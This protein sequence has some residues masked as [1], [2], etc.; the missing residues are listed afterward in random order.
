MATSRS[1]MGRMPGA[2]FRA[3]RAWIAGEEKDA[4]FY[5][6]L[7][8]IRV[9]KVLGIDILKEDPLQYQADTIAKLRV[10]YLRKN[11]EYLS[12]PRHYNPNVIDAISSMGMSDYG[13]K[14][15][16]RLTIQDMVRN[17]VQLFIE[18]DE[19]S[20]RSKFSREVSTRDW[21]TFFFAYA[22][23][24]KNIKIPYSTHTRMI[25]TKCDPAAA[26]KLVVPTINDFYTSEGF[27]CV[28]GGSS[29]I[30]TFPLK[31]LLPYGESAI[32]GI[33]HSSGYI[34]A[35]DEGARPLVID[36]MALARYI[37]TVG[38]TATS[39]IAPSQ[40]CEE[41]ETWTV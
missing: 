11:R 17:T 13:G 20:I 24:N 5:E 27:L 2:P 4:Y 7:E 31:H 19:A 30:Q 26:N 36:I 33:A 1:T 39:S 18:T 32:T 23:Y 8:L 37:N 38:C 15:E 14:V 12:G 34:V 3:A 22:Q 35:V 41:W 25:H 21:Y 40:Q 28:P 9:C 10:T 29:I 16:Q 6:A